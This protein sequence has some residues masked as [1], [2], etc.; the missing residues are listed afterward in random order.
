MVLR[1]PSRSLSLFGMFGS[2]E[3][4]H[5]IAG[6]DILV[7]LPLA[8]LR[9]R[10]IVQVIWAGIFL[11]WSWHSSL[12]GAHLIIRSPF[13]RLYCLMFMRSDIESSVP[14][15]MNDGIFGCSTGGVRP[16]TYLA[17]A[18]SRITVPVPLFLNSMNQSWLYRFASQMLIITCGAFRSD[19]ANH[20]VRQ[21]PPDT[22]RFDLGLYDQGFLA[23]FCSKTHVIVWSSPAGF[24]PRQ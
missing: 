11:V 23:Y 12:F 10:W 15:G 14:F 6:A 24:T 2:L 7:G 3:L 1:S 19:W 17:K 21:S 20:K 16:C 8:P 22:I 13:R 4:N 18:S 9:I 5:A